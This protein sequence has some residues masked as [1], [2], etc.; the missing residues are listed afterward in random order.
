MR[1]I[2]S[3]TTR[4][5]A[6]L[7]LLLAATVL[8]VLLN[9]PIL[10]QLLG[11]LFLTLVSGFLILTIL[12]LNR[13]GLTERFVLSVGISLFFLMAFGLLFNAI[14]LRIGY[15]TPLSTNTL[16]ISF[17]V[18][19]LTLG[20][21]AYKVNREA[22]SFNLS[23]FKLSTTETAF[24]VPPFIF[25]LLS[26]GGTYLMNTTNNN[27]ALMLLLFLIPAYAISVAVLRHKVPERILPPIILLT[28]I[29]LLLMVSLRSG[30]IIGMDAHYE[31]YLFQLTS[32]NSHWEIFEN[33]SLDACLSISLLPTIY[34]SFLNMNP[35]FLYKILY[36]L[37]I[38]ILPLVVYQ[39][40]KK[41]IGGFYAFFGSLF[42]LSTS[43]FI[44]TEYYV[45]SNMGVLFFALAI[46]VLFHD[47]ITVLGKRILFII[48]SVAV[49][50]SYYSASYIFLF[51]LLLTWIGMQI[52]PRVLA[53]RNRPVVVPENP[54]AQEDSSISLSKKTS[55]LGNN[56][57]A[58]TMATARLPS[59]KSRMDITSIILFLVMLFLWYSQAIGK[60]FSIA[61]N[62]IYGSLMTLVDFFLLEARADVVQKALGGSFFDLTFPGKIDFIANWLV[63][64]LVLIGL[65]AVFRSFIQST[66]AL[67]SERSALRTSKLDL[68]YFV[69]SL[70]C[71]AVLALSI[72]FP[73]VSSHAGIYRIYFQIMVPLYVILIIGGIRLSKYLRMP[74]FWLLLTVL[75][76]YF[77]CTTGT[78][79]QIFNEPRDMTLN[80]D[81]D[82]FDYLYV[83]DQEGFAARWLE[84]NGDLENAMIFHD[85]AGG[86][87]LM[88]QGRISPRFGNY[89]WRGFDCMNLTWPLWKDLKLPPGYIYLRYYNVTEGKLLDNNH[90]SH[91]ITEYQAKFT[92]RNKIYT[93]GG[94]E[95]WGI[96][97]PEWWEAYINTREK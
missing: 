28:G 83:Y 45:R 94:S 7:I 88:S 44:W 87:R 52:L 73:S 93:N 55:P 9:I 63:I 64:L 41:Y 11:F 21:I 56:T 65:I 15:V 69:L 8:A 31:Y 61:V 18:I 1:L 14:C 92:E 20:I 6:L 66:S 34:Q 22:F 95:I 86:G 57:T 10:R 97:I 32:S 49:I 25:P 78:I 43:N 33:S 67:E 89:P 27:V 2:N 51:I 77:M 24:L 53:R 84:D 59:L 39:I 75:I 23:D 36:V 29:S 13:L 30:H 82:Q 35:E 5:L 42:F 96:L 12:K 4:G 3:A 19:L 37:I 50:F 79:Y 90:E 46:M 74:P 38:S 72:V 62:F 60:P 54:E 68:E 85:L 16:M 58:L 76:P 70:V 47:E 26:I 48:F 40:S 91:N 80:S 71:F 17:G 81:G